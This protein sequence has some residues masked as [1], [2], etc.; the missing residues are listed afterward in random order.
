MTTAANSQTTNAKRQGTILV[1]S[2]VYVPDPT[3][4]GQHMADA[5][6]EMAAR[7]YRT[8]AYA[9]ANGYDDPTIKYER[10]ETRDGVDIQRFRFSSFGKGSIK[11]RLL[12]QFLFLIQCIVRGLFIRDLRGIIVSTSPPMAGIASTLLSWIRGAP[13]TF[14]AMDLNPDQMVAMG[15]ITEQSLP[16]R[17][18]NFINRRLLR[19][20]KAVVA[21]DRFMLDRLNRKTEVTAKSEVFPP[22]P[23][24]DHLETVAHEDNPFRKEQGLDGKFVVMYSGNHSPANPIG[25][26]IEAAEQL[27]DRDD[28]VF[29]FIGGGLQKQAVA[30]AIE[31][32]KAAGVPEDRINIRSLPYQ[33]IESLK[34]SLSSADLHVVTV[35]DE[36]VGIVH[37]CKV[38]GAMS[39]GRPVLT[40]GPESC[41]LSDLVS[42]YGIGRHVPHGDVAGA[43]EA[44]ESLAATDPETLASMGRSASEAVARDLSKAALCKRFGDIVDRSIAG[45]SAA[46]NASP[47]SDNSEPQPQPERAA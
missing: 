7:G 37:P 26:L 10:R 6:A 30:E 24:D 5:A 36:V 21:L 41:H 8:I 4:V 39:V 23:H 25:T 47:A 9:A 16:A 13:V 14:W 1:I 17:V 20:A 29:M 46:P 18:F 11:V 33:P 42:R 31:R 45:P 35:G 28:I 3:S 38:Y 27:R 12:A 34:Y 19:N 44:I 22:W 32:A 43:R 2:Q 15:M 40:F